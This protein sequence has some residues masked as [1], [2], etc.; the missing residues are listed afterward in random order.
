MDQP[1]RILRMGGAAH[2]IGYSRTTI[3]RKLDPKAPEYDP[4]FPRP[5]PLG[6]QAIGF[7]ERELDAWIESRKAQRSAVAA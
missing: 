3:Y 1:D 7:S 6:A 4:S 5:I 2:K